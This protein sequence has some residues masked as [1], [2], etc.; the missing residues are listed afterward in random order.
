VRILYLI[1]SLRPA[2]AERSLVDL[3]PVYRRF[4]IDLH[5]GLLK[6][7]D[8]LQ[9]LAE[10]HGATIVPLWGSAGHAGWVR[11][12]VGV[13]R[14]LRPD[15]IHTTLFDATMVGRVAAMGRAPLLHSLV[16]VSYGPEHVAEPRMG[17]LR[18]RTAQAL[19]M[20]TGVLVR[21]FHAVATYVADVM[22]QRL[23]IDRRRIDV[24]P[25]GRC[26]ETLGQRTAVRRADVRRRLGVDD[27][28]VLLAVGRHEPQ[29]ALDVVIS[30]F[31]G[32]RARH[33]GLRLLI[34]G[35]PGSESPRLMEAAR[36]LAPSAVR[37]L[38]P[39]LD[40][41]DIMCAADALLFPSRR[42][43]SPGT[44][45][46]ALA[47]ELPIVASD[48]PPIRE[49]VGEGIASLVAVDDGPGFARA[50]EEALDRGN[51][52]QER[53]MRGRHRFETLFTVESVGLR[54]KRLYEHALGDGGD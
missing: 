23:W 49:V 26:S 37:F 42:E 32:L 39:R 4:G 28:P 19:E 5:I 24:I 36:R 33:R 27:G 11:R 46:E 9:R 53:L 45:I 35:A 31:A 48:I 17:Y 1:D 47:L 10:E 30:A 18:S 20:A 54:M 15:L 21:R 3:V 2:G 52:Q 44:L 34:A 43:G 6:D 51:S 41:P 16:N 38:G 40:V 8:G 7:R 25:R 22:A 12:V 50:L 29:K 14:E 13:L